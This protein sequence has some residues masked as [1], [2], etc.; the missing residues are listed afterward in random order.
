MQISTV[1]QVIIIFVIFILLFVSNIL[2]VGIKN[3]KD[4]WPEYRCN[5]SVM[6][7][8]NIFGEDTASNFTYCIQTMQSNYMGYLTQPFNYNFNIINEL[9]SSITNAV[10]DV[11]AF[12]NNL[13][14]MITSVIQ[15]VFGTF[16]NIL[17]EFQKITM[18]IKDLFSKMIAVLATLLYTIMGSINTMQSA[19]AGPPGQLVQQLGGGALCF[20]PETKIMTE[21]GL[22]AMKNLT[23]GTILKNGSIVRAVLRIHNL[24]G[25]KNQVENLYKINGGENKD[26]IFVTGSHLIYN[27]S[28]KQF[29]K[30]K[31]FSTEITDKKCEEL[32]CLITSDHTI[33]I[34][35]KLFHD[36]E[37]NN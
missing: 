33:P 21:N 5:P 29:I 37:D 17:V 23:L 32:A 18:N 3:V 20:D 7:F 8:A 1:I 34:G 4:N 13:R 35:N 24:D 10:N 15:E 12:F 26:P 22:V 11:R 6:P 19:W 2:A 28:I 36:W 30:V 9:G 14:D 25:N 16:L 27:P 31:N